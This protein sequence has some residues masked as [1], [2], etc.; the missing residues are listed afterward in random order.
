MVCDHPPEAIRAVLVDD[1]L[2]ARQLLVELLSPHPEIEIVAECS[3]GFEAVKAINDL[4]PDLLFL[5]IQMPKLNGFEVLGLIQQENLLVVFVTAYDE[6][7][8]KAFEFHAADYLLK[9]VSA[10]RLE[11]ALHLVRKHFNPRDRPP[12]APLAETIRKGQPGLERILIRDGS[13]VHVIPV[14]KVDYVEAQDDY[15]CVRSEGKGY[16]KQQPMAEVEASLDPRR[17]IRIHRSYLLN[18]DRLSRLE[19]MTR[20]AWTAILMDGTQLPVSRKGY[21]RLKALL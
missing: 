12:L 6:F 18:L 4:K 5:D 14:R 7:A 13:R 20:E 2:L 8:L 11:R 19:M 9:P 16:L 17:F 3:N 1:E 10:E 21:E 15:I